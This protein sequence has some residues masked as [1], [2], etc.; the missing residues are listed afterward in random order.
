MSA[1]ASPQKPLRLTALA[2]RNLESFN[3]NVRLLANNLSAMFPNDAMV[4]RIRKRIFVASDIDPLLIIRLSGP[5]LFRYEKEIYAQNSAFLLENDY[6]AEIKASVHKERQDAVC[7]LIPR[8]KEAVRTLP[9]ADKKRYMST[10]I[11]MLDNYVE[12]EAER[13]GI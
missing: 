13:Q 12:F 4:E 10:I 9:D 5:Y 2:L 3:S 1:N 8:V 11:D 7:Y 6:D